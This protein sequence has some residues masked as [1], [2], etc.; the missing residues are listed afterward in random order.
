MKTAICFSGLPKN[1]KYS[2]ENLINNFKHQFEYF[3]IFAYSPVCD[4]SDDIA[5]YFGDYAKQIEVQNE[6]DLPEPPNVN[7]SLKTGLQKYLAQINGYYIVNQIR[8]KYENKN[9]VTYDIL[10]RCRYDIKF[11]RKLN[12]PTEEYKNRI[13]VPEFDNYGGYNDRFA[14]GPRDLMEEYFELIEFVYERGIKRGEN[15]EKVL[16]A[17]LKTKSIPVVTE[18]IF[19]NR[20][21]GYNKEQIT[22]TYMTMP[23]T[24]LQVETTLRNYTLYPA[25]KIV[26]RIMSKIYQ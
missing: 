24:G 22:D 3:D 19:F 13:V 21:R 16:H 23:I 15:A 2:Y 12:I 5:Q 1:L 6:S 9:G 20:I 17:M 8:K 14:V 18:E 25:R 7:G 11:A 26:D 10:V 4:A